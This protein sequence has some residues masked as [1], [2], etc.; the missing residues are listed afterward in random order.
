MSNGLSKPSLRQQ[1]RNLDA[2]LSSLEKAFEDLV[3]GLEPLSS[4]PSRLTNVE[5]VLEATAHLIGQEKVAALVA[6]LKKTRRETEIQAEKMA[7]VEGTTNGYVVAAD[8]V[9][10]DSLIVLHETMPNGEDVMGGRVQVGFRELT[11]NFKN[12][13][14]GKSVGYESSTPRGGKIVIKEIYT[15]DQEK[16]M[17]HLQAKMSKTVQNLQEVEK[18][19]DVQ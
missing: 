19:A 3:N 13:L 16:A 2:R 6:E 1:G 17:A 14:L 18:P 5:E 11:D 8:A 4:M 10:E 7:I 9:T 12:E 15:V